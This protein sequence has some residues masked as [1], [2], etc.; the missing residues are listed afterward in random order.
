MNKIFDTK[1]IKT[2]LLRKTNIMFLIMFVLLT[3]IDQI[4]KHI[5]ANTLQDKDIILFPGVLQLR[6]LENKGAA[7]GMLQNRTWF[8]LIITVIVLII[9]FVAFVKIPAAKKFHLLRFCLILLTAGAIG[10]FIDR[11]VNHYVIDF[12]YFSLINF[13]IF[14]VADCYVCI[15]AVLILYCVIFFYKDEDYQLS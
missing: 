10:N 7:W 12:I 14:N 2:K 13:P 4:T 15:S 11:I 3:F 5:A 9:V 8:L 6:Y 1:N